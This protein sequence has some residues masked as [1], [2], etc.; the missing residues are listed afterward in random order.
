M[1][2]RWGILLEF[3]PKP[4]VSL[5]AEFKQNKMPKIQMAGHERAR[6]GGYDCSLTT[7][8]QKLHQR[9]ASSILTF[10]GRKERV[11][12]YS[13]ILRNLELKARSQLLSGKAARQL[14]E[15]KIDFCGKRL[16]LF[17]ECGTELSHKPSVPVKGH[18]VVVRET[19]TVYSCFPNHFLKF[20]K[21][22][23]DNI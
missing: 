20:T 12:D 4:V 21:I 13:D 18:G 1:L 9:K 15:L 22:V 19:K 7:R 23:S 17:S 5:P 11:Q 6:G 10:L 8:N 16:D 2:R 3:R 14:T